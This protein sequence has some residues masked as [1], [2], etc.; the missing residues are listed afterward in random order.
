[1]RLL[2]VMRFEAFAVK[3][4]SHQPLHIARRYMRVVSLAGFHSD[5][6]RGRF[7]PA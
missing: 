3:N 7:K 1:M 4:A 5:L 2:A 6:M